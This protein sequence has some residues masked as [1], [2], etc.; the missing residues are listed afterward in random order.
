VVNDSQIKKDWHQR[1]F[2]CGIWTDPPNQ[3]WAD[4]VHDVDE[5]VM[6]IEGEIELSFNGK[7]FRPQIGQEI[8]I[9]AHASHTVRNVGGTTSRW[10]YGYKQI[11]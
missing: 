6:L 11:G 5:L 3:V 8:L 2:S 1:G 10:F 7:T 9:P 4:F